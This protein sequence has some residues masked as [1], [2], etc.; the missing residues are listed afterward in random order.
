MKRKVVSLIMAAT[1]AAALLAGCGNS[2][3]SSAAPEA[4]APSESS[5]EESA[6]GTQSEAEEAGSGA[7]EAD[8][9]TIA[10]GWPAED[11]N[12]YVPASA[13]GGTDACARVVAAAVSGQTGTNI[14][15]TNQTS[16]NGTVAY[17]TVRN[18]NVGGTDL[19]F[20]HANV[21]LNY[22]NDIYDH[23]PLESF[24]P[25]AA[26]A[27][28]VE[29]VVVVSSDSKYETLDDLVGAAKEGTVTAGVQTG[30]FDN[31][32]LSM[33]SNDSGAEFKF[34]E[35]GS[36]ADR[37]TTLLGGNIDC[38]VVSANLAAQYEETGDMRVLA[39]SASERDPNYPDYATCAE[40]GYP[41]T[42]F[43][44][45]WF[46]LG[47]AGMDE[48]LVKQMNAQ[49]AAI[50]DDADIVQYAETSGSTMTLM[51]VEETNEFLKTL[52]A[53][54]KAALGK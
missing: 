38:A 32:V 13:G 26:I 4:S 44:A 31:L 34:V 30:G 39:T 40:L 17:E 2:S 1:M 8:N 22:Y 12:F 50:A 29:Q 21:F 49:I 3:S 18:G 42:V 28:M 14:L 15:V 48:E 45:A 27:N 6:A 51:N 35:A 24:T 37:I 23:A 19:L 53:N 10:A 9:G 54:I 36:E 16:G 7:S 52:D 25:I 43:D 47:P 33:L 46:I 11:V 41:S 5:A 20:F